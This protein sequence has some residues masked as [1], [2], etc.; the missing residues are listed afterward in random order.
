MMRSF[1][2]FLFGSSPSGLDLVW[3]ILLT[4]FHRNILLGL[5]RLFLHLLLLHDFLISIIITLG[6]HLELIHKSNSMLLVSL[7]L[8]LFLFLFLSHLS[9][10]SLFDRWVINGQITVGRLSFSGNDAIPIIELVDFRVQRWGIHWCV[11]SFLGIWTKTVLDFFNVLLDLSSLFLFVAYVFVLLLHL[12][13]L[14]DQFTSRC[15]SGFRFLRVGR[16]LRW[17]LLHFGLFVLRFLYW[18][19]SI[20]GN[21]FLMNS[22]RL[23]WL[24]SFLR[25]GLDTNWDINLCCFFYF[26]TLDLFFGW[27]PFK[28]FRS[29]WPLRL[30]LEAEF[31]LRNP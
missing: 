27:W 10:Q 17:A 8:R 4:A 3:L 15:G 9:H 21:F 22:L 18:W 30:S 23:F 28:S 19:V 26:F 16:L 29:L 7:F 2:F 20:G 13:L 11:F 1:L 14:W 6:V 25:L 24:G 12:D 5:S 31:L